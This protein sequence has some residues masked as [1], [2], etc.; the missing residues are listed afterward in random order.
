VE[1]HESSRRFK[2]AVSLV[3]FRYIVNHAEKAVLIMNQHTVELAS[4]ADDGEDSSAPSNAIVQALALAKA[5]FSEVSEIF[6]EGKRGGPIP[7]WKDS[8][9]SIATSTV[10]RKTGLHLD[11]E[12]MFKEQVVIYP[13]PSDHMPLT[14]TAA[15]FLFMKIVIQALI[16]YSK[17][18]TFTSRG[19]EQ[20]TIDYL[21][22]KQLIPHYLSEKEMVGGV[23]CCSAL[24]GQLGDFLE[25]VQ[26][27]CSNGVG[28]D[29]DEG[30]TLA[31]ASEVIQAYLS[32]LSSGLNDDSIKIMLKAYASC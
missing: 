13:H 22:L 7:E 18:N 4:L 26:D 11:V 1:Q 14:A 20:A 19:Y 12:R 23:N 9:H 6:E 16:E 28:I 31:H 27:R 30:R 3:F 15:L 29:G 5:L 2:A 32:G 25:V 21:F 17:M 8:D 24:R 10:G